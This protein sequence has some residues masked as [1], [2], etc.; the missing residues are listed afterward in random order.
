M[1]IGIT[2]TDGSGKGTVVEYL[3]EQKGFAHYSAREYIVEEIKKRG[4]PI[5]RNQMRLVGNDLRRIHGMGHIVTHYL[6]EIKKN[7]DKNAVIE[8]IRECTAAE[9]LKKE[10]GILLAV[11]ADQTVRYSRVQERRSESD[12]VSFEQ[13]VGHEALEMNDPDPHGMQKQKVIGMTD[14]TIQNNGTHEELHVQIEKVYQ[15]I[16]K[17][18]A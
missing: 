9:Y 16:L 6:S 8:S 4:L 10:G 3:V 7:G 11:D 5:D 18:E 12:R 1:L 2:G 13:F 15:E 17:R 14:Y